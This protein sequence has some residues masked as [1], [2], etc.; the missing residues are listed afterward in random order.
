M[1]LIHLQAQRA[2]PFANLAYLQFISFSY[3]FKFIQ[4][5]DV[6]KAFAANVIHFL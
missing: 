4:Q 3:L 2:V 5:L 1:L 6:K